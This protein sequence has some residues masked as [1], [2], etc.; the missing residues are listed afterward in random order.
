MQKSGARHP[1]ESAHPSRESAKPKRVG[2]VSSRKGG[3]TNAYM[4][5]EKGGD[6]KKW[7]ESLVQYTQPVLVPRCWNV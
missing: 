5:K 7:I 1:P 2:C 6:L 4:E 3:H